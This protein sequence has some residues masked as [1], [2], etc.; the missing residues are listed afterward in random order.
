MK[1]LIT[2]ALCLLMVAALSVAVF[3]ATATFSMSPASKTV[4]RGEQFV[5]TINCENTTPAY[6]YGVQIKYDTAVFEI[7]KGSLHNDVLSLN[8]SVKT[9]NKTRGF[10]FMFPT[11]NDEGE[12][13]DPVAFSGTVGTVTFKVKDDAPMGTYTIEGNTSIS[14]PKVESTG[15]STAITVSCNHSYGAWTNAGAENHQRTCSKCGNVETKTH[16]WNSGTQTKA[17]TCTEDGVKTFT[18]SAC[19]ATKTETIAKLGHKEGAGVQTEAPTCT[20]DGVKSFSCTRCN[21]VLRTSVK[22]IKMVI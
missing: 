17:P 8:P 15:C 10:A 5:V 13:L 14:S 1:K 7:V 12:S 20:E 16:T 4:E 6:S 11:E 18:C 9:F 2:I 19:K 22:D 21:E 3:A